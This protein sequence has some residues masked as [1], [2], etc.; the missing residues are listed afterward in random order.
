MADITVESSAELETHL[1]GLC[2]PYYT[3]TDTAYII[4][5]DS[6]N[7]L[8]YKKSSDGGATW[9]SAV[10]IKTGDIQG[11]SCWFDQETPG[12]TGTK[13]HIAY[14]DLTTN[15]TFYRDLDTNGDTLGTERTI[16]SGITVSTFEINNQIGITKAVGGNLLVAFDTDTD[17]E[18]YFYRSTDSGANWTSRTALTEAT[19]DADFFLLFPASTADNADIGALFWDR[20]ANAVSIKMYDDSANTWTESTP[21]NL[22]GMTDTTWPS[23]DM[24]VRHSDNSVILAIWNTTDSA[25]GDME[26]FEITTGSIASPV[27]TQLTNIVTNQAE[28]GQ[29]AV[30]INQQN[31]DLYVAH[32]KGGTWQSSLD[33]V[34]YKSTDDGST[35]GSEQAYSEGTADDL[36]FVAGGRTIGDDGGK[37]QWAFFNEDFSDIYVNTTNDVDIAAGGTTTSTSSTSTSTTTS[38]STSTTTSQST[39]TSTSTSSTSTSTSSTSTSTTTLPAVQVS[40]P[41]SYSGGV[42]VPGVI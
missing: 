26:T 17:T 38:Q 2:G 35:W 16:L 23:W 4:Y 24:A 39:S 11:I 14:M 1:I 40:I 20:S 29:S 9:G 5:P 42:L 37:I 25:S 8:V 27:S 36:R 12:D 28:S 10:S 15:T 21:A 41:G 13:I 19:T 6:S 33:V 34:F 32:L 18:E 22:T 30:M 31:D 7:D 3:D